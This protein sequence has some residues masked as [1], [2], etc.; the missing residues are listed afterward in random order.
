[1]KQEHLYWNQSLQDNAI[2]TLMLLLAL[3]F[4]AYVIRLAFFEPDEPERPDEPAG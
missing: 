2:E 3:V 4:L 1:M